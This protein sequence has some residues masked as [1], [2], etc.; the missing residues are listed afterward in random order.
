MLPCTTICHLIRLRWPSIC[1]KLLLP[2]TEYVRLDAIEQV[3]VLG[4][5]LLYTLITLALRRLRWTNTSLS[6]RC[7]CN[8]YWSQL[9]CS[10]W[11]WLT[12]LSKSSSEISLYFCTIQFAP[13][14]QEWFEPA[15]K[16]ELDL[17]KFQNR[18]KHTTE[19]WTTFVKDLKVLAFFPDCIMMP[20][21]SYSLTTVLDSWLTTR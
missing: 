19:D 21:S 4:Q 15:T 8:N 17:V 16:K 5:L 1:H 10:L 7:L 18:L 12:W 3:F 6:F 11:I 2:W 14:K 20:R 13:F 9:G